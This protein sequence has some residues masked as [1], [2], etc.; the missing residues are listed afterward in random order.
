MSVF[1]K[2]AVVATRPAFNIV[3]REA[4]S[5]GY[6]NITANEVITDHT[7]IGGWTV[8]SAVSYALESNECPIKAVERAK[9]N[10]HEL[11]WLN[12]NA[13]CISSTPNTQP[14]RILI[15]DGDIVR[16]EGELFTIEPTANNNKVF[17]PYSPE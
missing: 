10:G 12:A 6:I 3:R 9:A 11:Y 7:M 1:K 4:D 13:T 5:K 15:E 16:F 17:V 14:D 8:S 2:Q